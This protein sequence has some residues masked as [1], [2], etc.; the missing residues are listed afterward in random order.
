MSQF[1]DNSAAKP[2]YTL[3]LLGIL[4]A[5]AIGWLSASLG[6]AVPALLVMLAFAI[7]FT[8]S[9]FYEPKYGFL[10]FIVFC[11]TIHIFTREVGGNIPYGTIGEALLLGTWITVITN[12]S[13]RFNWDN[14]K[15]DLMFLT[16]F[17]FFINLIEVFNPADA[18]I[19][20]WLQ[21]IRSTSLYWL[22]VVPLALVIFNKNK[23]LNLFLYIILGLSILGALN[24]IKQLY[25]GPWPGEQAFLNGPSQKTHILFGKLRVFSFYSDA[26]NFGASQAHM[27]LTALLLALGPFKLWKR[28]L[29]LITAVLLF[30]GMLISGTRGALYALVVGIAVA[31]FLG[32]NFKIIFLGSAI[33]FSLIFL[34]KFTSVGSGNY[35]VQRLRSALNPEDA[36]LGV[37]LYNQERLA[38]YLDTRPFGGGLGVI[39]F[40]GVKY[41]SDKYLASIPPDSYWVKVWAMYGIVGFIIWFGIMM[42]ILGKCCGIVWMIRDKRLRI[43]LLALTSGFAG[44]LFCSYGNEVMNAMPSAMIIYISWCFVFLGPK[45]DN[46]IDSN[47]KEAVLAK[48]YA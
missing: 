26:G 3:L 5:V 41:N 45:L 47:K 27:G 33:A 39:G 44:I 18:S 34:L 17:W 42:Y 31:I 12:S 16:L 14:L 19:M 35:H 23:D 37:R 1:I 30:Y 20:G 9:V 28:V 32:K 2:K 43:K 8:V 10:A 25:I 21:E 46:D 4:T 29:L 40:W 36:S 6:L 11:F 38:E 13:K 48:S 7:P 22:L 24:G 15:N